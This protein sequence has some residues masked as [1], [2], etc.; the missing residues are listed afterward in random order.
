VALVLVIPVSPFHLTSAD[1]FIG[2]RA[3]FPIPQLAGSLI[4][5]CSA[6]GGGTTSPRMCVAVTF[7]FPVGPRLVAGRPYVT[8][9]QINIEIHQPIALTM[10][11]VFSKISRQSSILS[12]S[13]S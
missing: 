11:Q 2:E 10:K 4:F 13:I 3:Y 1:F 12:I 9:R 7:L 5:P 6:A 8:Q